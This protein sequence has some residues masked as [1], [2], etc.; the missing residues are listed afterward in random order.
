MTIMLSPLICEDVTYKYSRVHE[1]WV[2]YSEVLKCV[3]EVPVGFVHDYESVPIIKGTS[4]RG[5]VA[6]DYLSRIDS[7]PVVTKAQASAVYF[8]IMK[9]RDQGDKRPDRL[10]EKFS[11]WWRRW[12]KWSV[13]RVWPGYFHKYP[14][15]AT[16]EELSG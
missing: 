2:F 5:G 12:L 10:L 3:I 1:P 14:V 8:E 6:H 16:L 7:S 9:L 15:M 4:K 13:V 11:L